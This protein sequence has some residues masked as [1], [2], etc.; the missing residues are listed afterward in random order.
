MNLILTVFGGHQTGVNFESA[1]DDGIVVI[2]P[3]EF[4]ST[5]F[6]DSHATTVRTIFRIELFQKNDAVRNAL[7]LKIPF[8]RGEIV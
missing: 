5:K 8:R 2:A 3:A 6:N 4:H 7:Q 1:G